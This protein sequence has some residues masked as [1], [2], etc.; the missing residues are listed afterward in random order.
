[1]STARIVAVAALLSALGSAASAEEPPSLAKARTLYNAANYEGAIDAA[2][3]A[4][5]DAAWADPAALVIAR[6]YLERYRLQADAEDLAAARDALNAVRSTALSPRDYVD[7]IVGLGQSLY[8]GEN[9]GAAA[10]LFDTALSRASLL[11]ARDS[12]LLLDWCATALDR[13]GQIRSSGRRT[14]VFERIAARME[15]EIRREPGNAVANYWMAVAARGQGDIDAAWNYAVA[16][17]VRSRLSMDTEKLRADL[18]RLM[19]QAL[20]PERA[21]FVVARD[22]QGALATLKTEWEI[23]KEQ[24]K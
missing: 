19:T 18:D 4:R 8:L 11:P 10:E 2:S 6:S 20:I 1:M 24:Y 23:L 3:V 22:Q 12:L 17:W 21:R 14:A 9:Y 15:A 13:E 16:A 5:M 7:Y